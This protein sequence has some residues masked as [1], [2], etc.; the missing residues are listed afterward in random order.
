MAR[1]AR[2]SPSSPD[3]QLLALELLCR[4]LA[5]DEEWLFALAKRLKAD[6]TRTAS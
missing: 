4:I 5:A 2:R 1:T 6:E 3:P